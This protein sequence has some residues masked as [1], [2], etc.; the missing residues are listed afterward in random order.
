M[1]KK[2]SYL[3]VF[4]NDMKEIVDMDVLKASKEISVLSQVF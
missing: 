4:L 3:F 2:M 1:K